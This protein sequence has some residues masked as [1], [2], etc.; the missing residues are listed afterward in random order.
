M[1]QYTGFIQEIVELY[2]KDQ[3]INP[4]NVYNQEITRLHKQLKKA[5]LK[6]KRF[7]YKKLKVYNNLRDLLTR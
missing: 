6:E 4:K 7:I 5:S 2:A 3:D 1:N